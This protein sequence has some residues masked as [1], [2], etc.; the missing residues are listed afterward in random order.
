MTT[1]MNTASVAEA[2]R[3]TSGT[4]HSKYCKLE[5]IMTTTMNTASVAEAY[6]ATS[7]TVHSKCCKLEMIMTAMMN[8]ASVAEAYRSTSG[9]VHSKYC[10]LE[11]IMT[12]TMNTASVAEAYRASAHVNQHST[13]QH[14]IWKIFCRA[15]LCIS[16]ASSVMRCPSVTFV[17]SEE[18]SKHTFIFFTVV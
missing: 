12:T 16:A 8:T 9:T 6:R 18:R 4:V 1:T 11:M 13:K 14:A 5:M 15:M 17:Y 7:G 3:S 10:K 2:Y